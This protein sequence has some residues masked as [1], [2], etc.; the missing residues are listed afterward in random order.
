MQFSEANKQYLLRQY[1]D[2]ILRYKPD[3]VYGTNCLIKKVGCCRLYKSSDS[4]S[5][6]SLTCARCKK[7]YYCCKECQKHD[8][9]NGHKEECDN[10]KTT[11]PD[12]LDT[13]NI[14]MW[15][16]NIMQAYISD[17]EYSKINR[18][19]CDIVNI[20]FDN[21]IPCV[22]I[23]SSAKHSHFA[24]ILFGTLGATVNLQVG[25]TLDNSIKLFHLS[26][27]SSKFQRQHIEP[28]YFDNHLLVRNL[29][30]LSSVL[31]D[32]DEK[33]KSMD[34]LAECVK[35]C[36][37][38]IINMPSHINAFLECM[39]DSLIP[40][41]QQYMCMG[42]YQNAND[43]CI[44]LLRYSTDDSM[45]VV[46]DLRMAEII[47][48]T[49]CLLESVSKLEILENVYNTCDIDI[50][51]KPV[52]ALANR[53]RDIKL[54]PKSVEKYL[55]AYALVVNVQNLPENYVYLYCI[56]AGL[57]H[58]YAL[59]GNIDES[60][61]SLEKSLSLSIHAN[62][63]VNISQAQLN[64]GV[65]TWMDALIG[66]DGRDSIE[67][68][69]S[70][71]ERSECFLLESL[72]QHLVNQDSVVDASMGEDIIVTANI[73]L[74]YIAWLR[75]DE[76]KA[77]DFLE[78]ALDRDISSY[79]KTCRGCRSCFATM[80]TLN[81]CGG[82]RVARSVFCICMYLLV[83]RS[84]FF[85]FHTGS[86]MQTIRRSNLISAITL[87][88]IQKLDGCCIIAYAK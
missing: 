5:T 67:E 47:A 55:D 2:N 23:G 41:L 81:K 85:F 10:I 19:F 20:A 21:P 26:V 42:D 6:P 59:N 73:H 78:F 32:N 61:L 48:I 49:G 34:V 82:C 29:E 76:I 15:F 84:F 7:M 69:D 50:K 83:H 71:L 65:V 24:A 74:A 70:I 16:Y 88:T 14:M 54:Y 62:E 44:D 1:K 58:S 35:E 79:D 60:I 12:K 77:F 27:L 9:Y 86:A 87:R 31:F 28:V 17:R 51:I 3:N 53:Y 22:T 4:N 25:N 52:I 38:G 64:L 39:Q 11:F 36:K 18:Y 57:G 40:M 37:I 45:K 72:A 43:V 80:D 75:N 63:V 56:Y 33:K 66:R 30:L 46:A 68:R 8:W 13:T